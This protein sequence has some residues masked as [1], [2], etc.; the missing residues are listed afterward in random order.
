MATLV[1]YDNFDAN[2]LGSAEPSKEQIKKEKET[3]DYF[4]MKLHYNYGTETEPVISDFFLELPEV[5][6]TGLR[7]KE[8]NTT[9]KNGS[10]VKKSYSQMIVFDLSDPEFKNESQIA[11]NKLDEAHAKACQLLSIRKGKVKMH[12]FDPNRPGG[13]FKSPVYRPRDEESGDILPGRNPSLWVKLRNYRNNKTLFTDLNGKVVDWSLLSDVDITFVP[14]LHIEKIYIGSKASLQVYLASAI[15]TKIVGVNT[16]TKQM[17]TLERLKQKKAGL[18][19]AVEAQLAEL[20]MARQDMLSA[21]TE[22]PHPKQDNEYGNHDEGEMHNSSESNYQSV[23][24]FLSGGATTQVPTSTQ[25]SIPTTVP[26]QTNEKPPL[27]QF[28]RLNVQSSMKIN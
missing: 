17:S 8:E 25:T 26:P 3:I 24:D 4:N 13:M 2:K 5:K 21:G 23:Q 11:I 20:R 7:L 9:G 10:Y 19:D 1:T 22:M 12:D 28:K 15:I 14:L 6:A 18:A 27:P 16:E